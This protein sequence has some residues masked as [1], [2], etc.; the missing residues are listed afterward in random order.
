MCLRRLAI[1]C[2]AL[3]FAGVHNECHAQCTRC[4]E[5]RFYF[6]AE[7]LL[8]DLSPA[9]NRVT[10]VDDI[11]SA[12]VMESDDANPDAAFLPRFMGRWEKGRNALE[13]S[14]WGMG[15]WEDSATVVGDNNLSL[16][17]AVALA[18]LDF[19][20]ADRMTITNDAQ[21]H[22]IEVNAWRRVNQSAE[23]LLGFRY[24]DFDETF[25]INSFDLDSGT[26]DY[27][28]DT[29]NELFTLQT[30]ARLSGC[31]MGW[32]YQAL[33]KIGAGIADTRQHTFLGDFNNTAVLR[34]SSNDAEE[35][36]LV[37]E[38]GLKFTRQL[39]TN[40]SLT[41]GYD[42]LWVDNIA[43]AGNQLDFTDVAGSGTGL[44]N[45]GRAFMHGG[46]LGLTMRL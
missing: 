20:A 33:G 21:I 7:S 29:E 45:H 14:Y 8:W 17:G 5:S 9:T 31:V 41:V 15:D 35:F 10:T 16:P 19:F 30:G 4:E 37:S 46:S 42:V 23:F 18:T 34:N 36:T 27:R 22:N 26:S 25:N 12:G 44:H 2:S 32:N 11:T 6:T 28:I 13:L 3:I 1:L 24:L 40:I 38:L 43:R 39:T